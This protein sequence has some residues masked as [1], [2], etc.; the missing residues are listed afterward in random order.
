M[1]ENDLI[2]MKDILNHVHTASAAAQKW[3]IT[4]QRV[5]HAYTGF[6]DRGRNSPPRFKDGEA[7]KCGAVLLV[8]DAGMERV[9]GKRKED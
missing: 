5:S 7:K 8:T 1:N 9:F 6:K 4:Q 3:G 2:R